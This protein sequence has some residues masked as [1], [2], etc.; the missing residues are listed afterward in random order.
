MTTLLQELSNQEIDWL[1]D[2]G[3]FREIA[4]DTV[5]VEANQPSSFYILLEG[6]LSALFVQPETG[7]RWE[8]RRLNNGELFG[9]MPW[10]DPAPSP[11]AIK[12]QTACAVLELSLP[13]LAEKLAH[14]AAFT[15]RLCRTYAIQMLDQLN[16]QFNYQTGIS[17]SM[18]A[19]SQFRDALTVF[20]ELQD[21][22]LDWMLA[23]GQ[24]QSLGA[25]IVLAR[26]GRPFDALHIVLEGSL[27]LNLTESNR[28]SD[29]DLKAVFSAFQENAETEVARLSRGEMVGELTFVNNS[30]STFTIRASRDSQIFSIP[31][32][33]LAAKLL[34][35]VEFAARFYRILAMLIASRQQA[36]M[37]RY[38]T[39]NTAASKSVNNSGDSQFLARIELA[40]ARFEWMQMRIQ[41]QFGMERQL[42]W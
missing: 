19:Q 27:I 41:T 2:H 20:A 12:A 26:R 17:V 37:Q 32:W 14:D 13:Q 7:Q 23:V 11:I 31:H 24:I 29:H 5:L 1:S 35:D 39:E 38:F 15:A 16:E 34:H 9:T 18:A 40:E 25:N 6:D 22:D 33:R 21:S 3:D 36:M 42:Q 8:Y 30:P 28:Q 10:L 4:V